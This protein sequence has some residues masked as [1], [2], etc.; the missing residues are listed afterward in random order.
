M[1]DRYFFLLK[2]PEVPDAGPFVFE[3]IQFYELMSSRAAIG[4]AFGGV[5]CMFPVLMRVDPVQKA[6][7]HSWRIF[8]Q[9][10]CLF[11]SFFEAVFKCCFEEVRCVAE[12]A[13]VDEE[14]VLGRT[15]F[16]VHCADSVEPE[17]RMSISG[18]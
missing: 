6:F 7:E 5:P 8:R 3:D 9:M 10:N 16:D 15:D 1:I 2:T 13:L 14:L 18:K 4:K 17:A 12:N 11:F